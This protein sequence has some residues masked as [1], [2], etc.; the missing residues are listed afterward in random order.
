MQFTEIEALRIHTCPGADTLLS[1][2]S[3]AAN[4]PK[5]L[6]TFHF[7]HKDNIESD[8]LLALD[9]FLC[10]TS[11]ITDLVIELG[12]VAAMP[13]AAGITR[14]GKTL[15]KLN[16]HCSTICSTNPIGH[17]DFTGDELVWSNDAFAKI[18]ED[19]TKLQQFSCAWPTTSLI[20]EPTDE[21]QHFED[22]IAD[23]PH[24]VTMIITNFP[25]NKPSSQLLPKVI[26]EQLLQGLAQRVFQQV[27]QAYEDDEE[28][29]K[30]VEALQVERPKT[31]RPAN[32]RPKLR[33]IAFGISNKIYE[34]EDS[35]HQLIYLRST[36]QDADGKA[37]IYAAP[38]SWCLTQYVEG[39]SDILQFILNR[40]ARTPWREG[41]TSTGLGW[42]PD[43]D[44]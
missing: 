20:R 43:D 33:I 9:G 41:I 24:L 3:K 29:R 32:L 14:H 11:G 35:K 23:L 5:K 12:D 10:L 30:A 7:Q 22:S 28:E 4:L 25:N 19:C 17:L 15:E 39:N 31:E 21:W 26:Y 36:C 42:S 18:C 16:V 8:A 44:D 37:Q 27:F 40:R 38:I 34:R 2:L 6:K 1:Q 13:A